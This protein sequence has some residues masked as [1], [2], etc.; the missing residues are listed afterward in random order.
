MLFSKLCRAMLIQKRPGKA[1][2]TI[3]LPCRP[4][5]LC[6]VDWLAKLL[7]DSRLCGEP[8][9]EVQ[10]ISVTASGG[11][12]LRKCNSKFMQ[13]HGG[14]RKWGLDNQ[15]GLYHF[16]L[17]PFRIWYD[18]Y[19]IAAIDAWDT[20]AMA[21]DLETPKGTINAQN[22]LCC[23]DQHV[24]GRV[25]GGTWLATGN[26]PWLASSFLWPISLNRHKCMVRNVTLW[27]PVL[28]NNE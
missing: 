8:F 11:F 6:A 17:Q 2:A 4:P 20:F 5:G 15:Q 26:M 18:H 24:S 22:P 28:N 16:F 23:W 7:E 21:W 12:S 25:F 3:P 10:S 27:N 19:L 9:N 13:I 1:T 14:K